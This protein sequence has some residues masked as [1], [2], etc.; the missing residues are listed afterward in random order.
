L[1]DIAIVLSQQPARQRNRAAIEFNADLK[2]QNPTRTMAVSASSFPA[3]P[4][5]RAGP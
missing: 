1:R 3:I 4:A 5:R 2:A